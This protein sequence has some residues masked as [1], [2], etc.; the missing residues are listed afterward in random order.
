MLVA[1]ENFFL[2]L[3]ITQIKPVETFAGIIGSVHGSQ[4]INSVKLFPP[5][6]AS[7]RTVLDNHACLFQTIANRI[8]QFKIFLGAGLLT[9]V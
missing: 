2:I 3:G 8:A 1:K 9:Q 4:I 6:A 5:P 7:L